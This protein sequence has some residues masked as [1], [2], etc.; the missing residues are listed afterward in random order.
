MKMLIAFPSLVALVTLLSCG[1][2]TTTS[3]PKTWEY[4]VIQGV[5]RAEEFQERL[6]AVAAEG[7]AIDSSTFVPGNETTQHQMVLILKRQ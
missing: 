1:C 7:Y 4:R 5:P 6:N 3:V 2:S